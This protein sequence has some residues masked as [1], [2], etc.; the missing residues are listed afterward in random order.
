MAI[1]RYQKDTIMGS[2]QR[3]STA[4]AVL[5]VR[6]AQAS[7]RFTTRELVLSEG[8]RLDH[9]AG[10]LFGD[11]GLWWVIAATSGIGWGLQVPPG[12]RLLI[13]TDIN[14]VLGFV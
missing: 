1:S 9:I 6:Q 8:Q 14:T 7:G 11:G 13:P 2:P 12:T 5:R 3:L 10:Q 4:E